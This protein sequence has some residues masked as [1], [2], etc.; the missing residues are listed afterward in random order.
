[1]ENNNFEYIDIPNLIELYDDENI[2]NKLNE[3]LYRVNENE[4]NHYKEA[5]KRYDGFLGEYLNT[6]SPLLKPISN[7]VLKKH[8]SFGALPTYINLLYLSHKPE[9]GLFETFL[10]SNDTIKR[11]W[12]ETTN[13]PVDELYDIP[14]NERYEIIEAFIN[15][16]VDSICKSLCKCKYCVMYMYKTNPRL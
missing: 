11:I 14:Q 10:R 8:S 12:N 9:Y 1:M 5:I 16:K 4:K 3:N 15:E 2:V 13:I 6:N 7:Y